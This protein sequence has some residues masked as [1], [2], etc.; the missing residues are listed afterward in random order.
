MKGAEREKKSGGELVSCVP[1][2]FS[3]AHDLPRAK[4]AGVCFVC[5]SLCRLIGCSWEA[6]DMSRSLLPSGRSSMMYQNIELPAV[7]SERN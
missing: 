1:I 7:V 4:L 3:G 2:E 6:C 5:L